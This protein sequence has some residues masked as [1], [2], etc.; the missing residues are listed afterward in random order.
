MSD[1]DRTTVAI[2][3]GG[4]AALIGIEPGKNAD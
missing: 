4:R 2:D 3:V 1:S